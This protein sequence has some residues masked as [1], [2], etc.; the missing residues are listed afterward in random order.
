MFSEEVE[1]KAWLSRFWEELERV[2][3][4]EGNEEKE[5][6][7]TNLCSNLLCSLHLSTPE[8]Y[9]IRPLETLLCLPRSQLSKTDC[10]NL[11]S[12]VSQLFGRHL[13][14]VCVLM[15]LLLTLSTHVPSITG[16]TVTQ[17]LSTT[18]SL[19]CPQSKR[20]ERG[21]NVHKVAFVVKGFL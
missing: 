10:L 5:G 3:L 8:P 21:R 18:C 2:N 6:S 19:W 11:S 15:A 14:K 7:S 4:K 17:L 13:D 16:D 12:F 1:T 9:Y 20:R